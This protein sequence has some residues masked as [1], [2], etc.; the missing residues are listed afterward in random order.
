MITRQEAIAELTAEGKPF[1][2]QTVDVFGNPL[3]VFKNAPDSLR[4]VW[5]QAAHENEAT[6]FV[7]EDIAV[8]YAEAHRQVV[9]VAAWLTAQGVKKGDRVALGM[10]NYPEWAIAYWATQC[11]GAVM[12]SLNAWWIADEL[13]YALSDSG[14]TA[15]IVDGERQERLSDELLAELGISAAV[16]ARGSVRP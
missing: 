6:Y 5:L 9:S 8:T 12:V 10:R 4:D 7:Y 11:I 3:R 15:V 13:K 16:V 1:E 2:L 14:A